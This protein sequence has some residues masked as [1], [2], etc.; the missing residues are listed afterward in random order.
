MNDN[1]ARI[2]EYLS[3]YLASFI[4][5]NPTDRKDLLFALAILC[6]AVFVTNKKGKYKEI[7]AFHGILT[8]MQ[9]HNDIIESF[10]AEH[11]K[12]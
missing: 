10:E 2:S 4:K 11:G 5:E 3:E 7:D 1:V 6:S 8:L 12:I 9:K